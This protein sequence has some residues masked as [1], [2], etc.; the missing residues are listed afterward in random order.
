VFATSEGRSPSAEAV[1]IGS[2]SELRL[3][4]IGCGRLAERGYVP[5]AQRAEGVRLAAVADPAPGRCTQAAPGIPSFASAADLLE[6]GAA[7]LLVLAT[8][9]AAHLDDASLAAA[10]GVP[11]LVEKPPAPTEREAAELAGLDPPPWIGFN[12]RFEPDLIRLRGELSAATS[13][14][15]SLRFSARRSSWRPYDVR[16]GVLLDLGPHL[17]DL[18]FW[19]SRGRP[20]HVEGRI[21]EQRASLVIELADRRGVARIECVGNRPYHERIV[22]RSSGRTASFERGGLLRGARALLR[23]SAESPLV[24]SLARQLESFAR[25]VRGGAEPELA[26]AADGL[27]VMRTLEA[28]GA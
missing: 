6:A 1:R 26:T 23:P 2:L 4:L 27:A 7:D 28:A 3:G 15:L 8:P 24:P 12:R 21:E 10:A 14:E 20:E 19:L 16:D 13:V 22:A 5:A 18:A 25:A 11:V 17:V 9:A